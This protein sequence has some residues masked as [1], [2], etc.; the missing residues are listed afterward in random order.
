[1]INTLEERKARLLR[2]IEK[3]KREVE[4]LK[5]PECR[6]LVVYRDGGGVRCLGTDRLWENL[7]N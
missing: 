6:Q 4:T 5:S 2:Q 7:R 3:L 1:M